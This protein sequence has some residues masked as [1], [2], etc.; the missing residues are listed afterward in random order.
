M[1]ALL[2]RLQTASD[3][4][5]QEALL[6]AAWRWGVAPEAPPVD[7]PPADGGL[8]VR[9]G[10]AVDLLAARVAGRPAPDVAA[11]LAA[12]DLVDAITALVSPTG[13][14]AVTSRVPAGLLPSLAAADGA[15]AGFDDAWLPVVAA[16]RDRLAA[17]EAHQLAAPTELGG[18]PAFRPWSNKPVDPWQLDPADNRRLVVAYAAGGLALDALGPADPVALAAL[19]RFTEVVPAEDQ[20]TG[21]AFG[22]DAPAARAPQAILLAVPPDTDEGLTDDVVVEIV[23]EARD[24]G[25]ARMARPAD[26]PEDLTGLLPSA[27]LPATGAT[28]VPIGTVRLGAV[29]PS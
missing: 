2:T 14:V 18:G 21:A 25:R 8:A 10:R 26:L 28:A 12:V 3:P 5:G 20:T 22:F 16:V 15:P 6:R 27:L 11:S 4:A 23:A 1:T 7:P 29:V 9:V 17:V 24:L 19:D 13:Q